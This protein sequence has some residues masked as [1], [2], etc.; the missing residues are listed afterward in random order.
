MRELTNPPGRT[1]QV[2]VRKNSPGLRGGLQGGSKSKLMIAHVTA[3]VTSECLPSRKFTRRNISFTAPPSER[4][5]ILQ[6]HPLDERTAAL[7]PTT[8][9]L[10]VHDSPDRT[11]RHHELRDRQERC[12]A[13][14]PDGSLRRE[15][16]EAYAGTVTSP[17]PTEF[18][19]GTPGWGGEK[20]GL[21]N[22]G[23][24]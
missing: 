15:R 7:P 17:R 2:I 8:Q 3:T 13:A 23:T 16:P 18:P 21:T 19:T 9:P 11:H 4:P 22:P 1:R 6:H 10:T 24:Q 12:H 14:G 20:R 5:P